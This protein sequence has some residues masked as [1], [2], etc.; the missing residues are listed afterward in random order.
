MAESGTRRSVKAR[1]ERFLPG[2]VKPVFGKMKWT[3]LRLT[4]NM[5]GKRK[6]K[7]LGDT[8]HIRNN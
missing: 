1:K 7:G 8:L 3:G 2:I 5:R 6:W 4:M